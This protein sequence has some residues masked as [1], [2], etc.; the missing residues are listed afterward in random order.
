MPSNIL[1]ERMPQL[2]HSKSLESASFSIFLLSGQT[3]SNFI[4][5][6]LPSLHNMKLVL[7]LHLSL[8]QSCHCYITASFEII[9][10]IT[11]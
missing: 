5:P 4:S 10:L 11:F 9:L 2:H 1:E 3:N 6:T 8:L 7:S